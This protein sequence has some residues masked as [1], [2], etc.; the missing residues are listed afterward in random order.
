MQLNMLVSRWCVRVC[1]VKRSLG[2][3]GSI[4]LFILI[5]L[6]CRLHRQCAEMNDDASFPPF[7]LELA[8][9][10]KNKGKM[11]STSSKLTTELNRNQ[12]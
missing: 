12:E 3:I 6:F 4:F 2:D 7:L 8:I 9:S 5:P 10:S 11:K 1:L